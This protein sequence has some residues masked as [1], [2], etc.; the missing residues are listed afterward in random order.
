M[1]PTKRI[2]GLEK[3]DSGT[4]SVGPTV[5]VA[6]NVVVSPAPFGPITPTMQYNR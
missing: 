4:L 2:V 3:P 6:L 1:I 5:K